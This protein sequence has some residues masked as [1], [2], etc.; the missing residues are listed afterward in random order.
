MTCALSIATFDPRLV[1]AH[2]HRYR[3][4]TSPLPPLLS[5]QTK[6][7]TIAADSNVNAQDVLMAQRV[8]SKAKSNKKRRQNQKRRK[9]AAASA[10]RKLQL[11][12]AADPSHK[13]GGKMAAVIRMFSPRSSGNGT[14]G[15]MASLFSP[16]AKKTAKAVKKV[17][18][19]AEPVEEI[20]SIVEAPSADTADETVGTAESLEMEGAAVVA[21]NVMAAVEAEAKVVEE[22]VE[23]EKPVNLL[24]KNANAPLDECNLQQC[25]IL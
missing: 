2:H 11:D 8:Q 4:T 19:V 23:E 22:E 10:S 6:K 5:A 24:G 3:Q 17:E 15:G 25:I 16:N 18:I 9:N 20:P 13:E 14:G 1:L 12:A 7:T 21:N